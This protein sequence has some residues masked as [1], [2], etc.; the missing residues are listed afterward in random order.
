VTQE[1]AGVSDRITVHAAGRGN[2]WINLRDGVDLP[3][4]YTGAAELKQVLEQNL[5]HPLSLASG[6]FDEDGVPDLV[7]GYRGLDGGILS[8]HRG[9]IDSIYPNS[10]EA[11]QRKA[12]GQFTDLPFLSPAQV[13]EV[14]DAPDF[15]GTGDFDADGHWDVVAAVRGS[16]SL[17]LLPGNGRGGF[18]PAKQIELPGTVTA[19]VTGEI[20]RRDGLDD[21][22]AGIVGLDGPQLLVFEGPE[23]ALGGKPEAFALPGEATALA[24]GHLDGDYMVD[25]AVAAGSELLIVHG[26]DRKLSLDEIRRAEVPP[27]TIDQRSFPFAIASVALGDFVWDQDHR[28]DIALLSEDGTVHY[29]RR[30]NEVT[31][32]WQEISTVTVSGSPIHR[33]TG[34]PLLLVR[35]HVSSLPT[36]DL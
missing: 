16:D 19:L 18:D 15:L 4:A 23:G 26:R 11:Q 33:V 1:G 9:N 21:V 6:D 25:L 7:S 13:F 3:I 17:Y 30:G 27:A 32:V 36:D 35:A 28:T 2:P 14:P 8:L 10:P 29:L 20:N 5:A 34:S 12:T 31:A 22:V 24:L